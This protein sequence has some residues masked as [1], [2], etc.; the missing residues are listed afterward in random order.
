MLGFGLG[1]GNTTLASTWS[2]VEGSRSGGERRWESSGAGQ[3]RVGA[4][5]RSGWGSAWRSNIEGRLSGSI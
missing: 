4:V 1:F 3:D 2:I 5:P